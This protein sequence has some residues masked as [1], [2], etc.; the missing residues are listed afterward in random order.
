M[1]LSTA[2]MQTL[3]SASPCFHRLPWRVPAVVR[4][5]KVAN[6]AAGRKRWCPDEAAREC[7][8]EAKFNTRNPA[9]KRI[10]QVLRTPGPCSVNPE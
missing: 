5:L 7:S 4:Q 8:M 6:T 1:W 2:C 9:V 10:M 3:P